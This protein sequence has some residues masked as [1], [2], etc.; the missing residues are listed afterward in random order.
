MIPMCATVGDDVRPKADREVPATLPRADFFHW[1]L[2]DIPPGL[3]T[4]SAGTHSDGVIARG[5]PG[6]D[7][8]WSAPPWPAA[9]AMALNDYTA[10]FAGDEDM[11]GHYFGY[12]GPCPP[13]N[14]AL[15]HRYVFTVYALDIERLPV[16]GHFTG[17]DTA[18]GHPG[19]RA[20]RSLADRHLHAQ[21]ETDPV[22]IRA[23]GGRP[24]AQP[25]PPRNRHVAKHRAAIAGLHPP[26]R[27]PSWRDGL[28]PRAAPAGPAR[29]PAQRGGPR[30]GGRAWP[31]RWPASRSTPSI[32]ATWAAPWKP[33]RRWPRTLGLA[34]AADARL[35]ER[36]Y[37]DLEGHDL[38][39]GGRGAPRGLRALAGPACLDHAPPRGESLLEFHERAVEA[40][41]ALSRRHPGER[42]ALVAHGG[43]LDCLYREATGMTLEA[44]RQHELLNASVN[45]LRS[46]SAH[47][48]LLQWGDVSH[49]E[50]LALD[51]VDKRVP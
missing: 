24:G 50:A 29:Y 5:K 2:V 3:N 6:P 8:R 30:P 41:L 33:P 39:R 35:R 40:A 27:D 43:V 48:T 15:V 34:G 10:W 37:G 19:P 26:D 25:S 38:C 32:R 51:E 1:V 16:E 28:E 20:G 49:L 12:D 9:C 36:C 47:L 11:K 14:D 4:I 22:I 31:R 42:I 21:P 7:A 46:D 17:A 45:R 18:R 13:W 44:P 23:P